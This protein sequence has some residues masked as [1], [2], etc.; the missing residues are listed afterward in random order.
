MIAF[1]AGNRGAALFID[2][3]CAHVGTDVRKKIVLAYIT[4][5][6]NFLDC[7]LQKKTSVASVCS[8]PSGTPRIAGDI[9]TLL[10]TDAN[11]EIP[12]SVIRIG[13][14]EGARGISHHVFVAAWQTRIAFPTIGSIVPLIT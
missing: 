9:D 6:H 10:G 5:T 2:T 3:G 7:P 14:A 8:R 11:V 1:A 4:H 13:G 12:C